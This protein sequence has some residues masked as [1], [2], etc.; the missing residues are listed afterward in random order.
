VKSSTKGSFDSP[1]I[2]YLNLLE[3]VCCPL[4]KATLEVSKVA[5]SAAAELIEG[6]LRCSGCAHVFPVIEGIP[7]L[8]PGTQHNGT[9]SAFTF[10]WQ[11]SFGGWFERRSLYGYDV[12]GLVKWVFGNCFSAVK[13]G[14]RFL[15]AGCG[16][17]DKTIEIAR[18]YPQAQVLGLDLTNTLRLSRKAAAGLENIHF[19]RG[20]LLNLPIR[21]GVI[22]RA[23]SWGVMHHTPDTALAFRSVAQTLCPFGELAVWLYPNPADSDIFNMAYEMRDVHFFGRGHQIPRPLLLTVLPLYILVTAPYFLL[24]YGNPLRDPRVVRDYLIMDE[25]PA[26]DKLRATMFIYL[27]NLIPTFQDRPLRSVVNQWYAES[28]FGSVTWNDPGLFWS[29]KR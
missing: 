12:A 1:D 8:L 13:N 22:T 26:F 29:A 25:M 20:D 3:I 28:G 5:R 6:S 9:A 21:D 16:R 11:L 24:R 27:D 14:D 18:R 17:G 7:D 10:Q 23:M 4:C 19:V 15:D 2:V